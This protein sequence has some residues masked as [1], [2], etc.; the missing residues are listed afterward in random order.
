VFGGLIGL[1]IVDPATGAMYKLPENSNATLQTLSA[2]SSETPAVTVVDI[3]ILT[4]DQR[5]MMVR[6]L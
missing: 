5:A 1:L 6:V 2:S 4:E 3:S